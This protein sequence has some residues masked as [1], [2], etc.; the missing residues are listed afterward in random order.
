MKDDL[1]SVLEIE[2]LSFPSPW[3]RTTFMGELE[4]YPVSIPFGI[5]FRPN[6]RLIGYIILWFIQEEVQI[7]NF[8]LHPDFRKR[9]VGE[10]V[11]RDILDKIAK[12]GAEEIFLEVRPSNQGARSLYE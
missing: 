12:E 9:G 5:I 10:G 6:D 2:H 3:R 8:A 1:D 4:N 11:L 7:S